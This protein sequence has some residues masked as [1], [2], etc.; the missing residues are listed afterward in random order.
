MREKGVDIG[1]LVTEV[2]PKELERMGLVNGVWVCTYEEFKALSLVLREH[3]VKLS[4]AVNAQ[5]NKSD[6][7]SILYEYLTSTE[8]RMQIEA[9]VEGFTQMQDDLES[10]K[11]AFARIWKQREKQIAKVLDNTVGMYGT[12]RGIAGSSV[13]TIESLEL[14]SYR[15]Q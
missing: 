13:E 9:I 4:H 12:I 5:E 11:R 6:K 10:E 14:P 1:V 7:M 8:F 3:I 15:I 2:L